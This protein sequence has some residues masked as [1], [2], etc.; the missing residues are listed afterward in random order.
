M[1]TKKKISNGVFPILPSLVA[2][3]VFSGNATNF[4]GLIWLHVVQCGRN[5][6]LSIY[7]EMVFSAV[8]NFLVLLTEEKIKFS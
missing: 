4:D 3:L 6:I 5:T 8:Y 7:Y 1:F 2:P